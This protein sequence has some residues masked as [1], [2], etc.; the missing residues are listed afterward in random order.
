MACRRL[1]F[2]AG[3]VGIGFF[4]SL[5]QAQ[6]AAP[7]A[8]VTAPVE[9][10]GAA[11]P[12]VMGPAGVTEEALVPYPPGVTE[13]LDARARLLDQ[14][15]E[16]LE[17]RAVFLDEREDYLLD[18]EDVLTQREQALLDREQALAELQE[19]L[20]LERERIVAEPSVRDVYP[21]GREWVDPDVFAPGPQEFVP[22]TEEEFSPGFGTGFFSS[23]PEEPDEP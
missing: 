13:A 9:T 5:L 3:A 22:G 4:P 14:R 20:R 19:S 16:L 2:L 21:G 17:E 10:D 11:A 23:P 8:A 1:I 15:E 18:R 6:E 7:P 12:A